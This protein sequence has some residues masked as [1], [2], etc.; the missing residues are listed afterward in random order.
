MEK[1]WVFLLK[2]FGVIPEGMT[3]EEYHKKVEE[4]F[5]KK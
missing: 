5:K 4:E 3:E 2:N 1:L